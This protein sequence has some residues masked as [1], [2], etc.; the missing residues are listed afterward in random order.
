MTTRATSWTALWLVML[1]SATSCVINPVPTPSTTSSGGATTQTP[2]GADAVA[3]GA[4]FA[5][6]A[7]SDTGATDASTAAD[8]TAVD[9]AEVPTQT[10]DV[11]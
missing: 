4:D 5:D 7:A 11:Q 6:V 10:G 3:G 9:A 1:V 2:T 8:T